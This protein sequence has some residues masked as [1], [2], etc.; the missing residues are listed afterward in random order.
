MTRDAGGA[1]CAHTVGPCNMVARLR[2][3]GGLGLRP[4]VIRPRGR[5]AV[6]P[7]GTRHVLTSSQPP[8]AIGRKASSGGVVPMSL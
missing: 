7:A 8:S 1:Q 6:R 4:V 3:Q 5:M 2:S